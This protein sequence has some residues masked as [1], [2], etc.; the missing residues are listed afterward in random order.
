[1]NHQPK[2][3]GYARVSARDQNLARQLNAFAGM[4]IDRIYSDKASGKNF[5][6]PEYRRM[7]RGLHAGDT[8]VITSIDRL[9]RN[10]DEIIEQWRIITKDKGTDVIVLDMPLL[11]T[12]KRPDNITGAFIADL[13]LQVLSY[14]AQIERENIKHRQAEGIAAAKER[15]VRFGRPPMP[16]PDG[17]EVVKTRLLDKEITRKE[18]ARMMGI[19]VTTLAKWLRNDLAQVDG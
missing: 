3:Y 19:S 6:R 16:R 14:V 5:E 7:L 9:G 15:G 4:E 12:K 11:N 8:L 10:Y 17:Y 2:V 1:M 13:V 18:A